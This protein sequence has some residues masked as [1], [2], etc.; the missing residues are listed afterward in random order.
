MHRIYGNCTF[1]DQ[2]SKQTTCACLALLEHLIRTEIVAQPFVVQD[3][4]IGLLILSPLTKTTKIGA[5][6]HTHTSHMHI[7]VNLLHTTKS[8]SLYVSVHVWW[9]PLNREDSIET[10][11]R[12][13]RA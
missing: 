7:S 4:S 2:T 9:V 12:V 1:Y 13:A 10:P 11:R 3:H 5:H 8:V 6:T